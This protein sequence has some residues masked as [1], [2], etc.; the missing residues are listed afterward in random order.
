MEIVANQEISSLDTNS[1]KRKSEEPSNG[2]LTLV[3]KEGRWQ[4]KDNLTKEAEL[5]VNDANSNPHKKSKKKENLPPT[6]DNIQSQIETTNGSP[7]KNTHEHNESDKKRLELEKKL[8]EYD[9]FLERIRNIKTQLASRARFVPSNPFRLAILEVAWDRI[10][11]G[12][13]SNYKQTL[14]QTI[15]DRPI[16]GPP[17]DPDEDYGLR[18]TKGVNLSPPLVISLKNLDGSKYSA[19]ED[20]KLSLVNSLSK[21]PSSVGVCS[22]AGSPI[23]QFHSEKKPEI[24]SCVINGELDLS[25][26]QF[27]CLTGLRGHCHS[28]CLKVEFI[29]QGSPLEG[30]ILFSPRIDVASKPPFSKKQQQYVI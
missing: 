27:G 15:D 4:I 25:K 10:R 26:L 28:F 7:H 19:T 9:G 12:D 6:S 3:V 14:F 23:L 29:T 1:K 22:C 2:T 21:L 13:T 11:T 17:E 18:L 30:Q 5:K 8:A 24:K 20:I 16:R